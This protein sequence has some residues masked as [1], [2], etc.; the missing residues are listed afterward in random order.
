MAPHVAALP[1]IV[2]FIAAAGLVVVRL[3]DRR[4]LNDVIAGG[5][6]AASFTLCVIL[7]VRAAHHPFAYWMGGWRP[8]HGVTIG[9]SLSVDPLGAGLAAF[10]AFL[11]LAALAYAVRYFDAVSGLFQ[12]LM[13]LFGAAMV[14]FCL[15][16][17]L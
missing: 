7:L 4:W 17:D 13:L 15:T 12:A 16:G 5:G 8:I 6:M 2:P 1:V 14:G 11:V 10:A 9:I 3:F